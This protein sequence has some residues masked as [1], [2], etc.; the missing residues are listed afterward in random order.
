M[1]TDARLFK[2][3]TDFITYIGLDSM[4]VCQYVSILVS[5]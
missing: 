4:K 3:Y 2:C 5:I 1:F